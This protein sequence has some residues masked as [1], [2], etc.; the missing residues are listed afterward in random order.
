VVYI[1]MVSGA[2]TVQ[3]GIRERSMTNE[4]QHQWKEMAEALFEALSQ[5]KH[6]R[7]KENHQKLLP[8]QMAHGAKSRAGYHL[9]INQKRYCSREFE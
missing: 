2:Q 7:T 8:P 4:M 9:N 3:Q 5:Q 1:F 6:E